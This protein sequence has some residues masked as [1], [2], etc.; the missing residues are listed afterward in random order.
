MTV[1]IKDVAERAGV[2]K[3]TVSHVLNKTRFVAEETRKKV[4]LAAEY[5]NYE[6]SSVARSL[7]VKATKS[8][9][10]IITSNMNPFFAEIVRE[11]EKFSYQGGYN[12]ILCNT[13]NDPHKTKSY[14]QMLSQKRVDG[15]LVMCS[16][17]ND[18][19]FTTIIKQKTVPLVVMDW[20]PSVDF[21]DQIQDNSLQ[22]GMLATQHLISLGHSQIGHIA[23]PL[24]KLQSQRRFEG[25]QQAMTQAGL[26]VNPKWVVESDFECEGGYQA[27]E[28][29]LAQETLPTAIFVGN[30]IM[31]MGALSAINEKGLRVPQDI[32]LVG[33][34]NISLSAFF[35]PALTT[36]GQPFTKLAKLAIDTLID[37]LEHPREHGKTISLEPTLVERASTRE[38][39]EN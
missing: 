29:I 39:V 25:F 12:L 30:D 26:T 27:M 22:G 31:A 4:E 37:R 34:D 13:E 38:I 19:L 9:G 20:G 6:P 7:K 1:T 16:T 28:K 35:S 15:I 33:Y 3:T 14:M 23:G 2:S 17:F 8:L 18:H 32:S 10:M 21:I 11:I 5:L 24:N 36:V